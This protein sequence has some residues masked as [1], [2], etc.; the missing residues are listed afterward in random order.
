[1]EHANL[2]ELIAID[3][4]ASDNLTEELLGKFINN[5]GPQ[6]KGRIF[7][8]FHCGIAREMVFFLARRLPVRHEP[9]DRHPVEQ[10][11]ASP[12]G[13]QDPGDGVG[14]EDGHQDTH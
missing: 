11:A 2:K 9:R 1:M 6:L 7:F 3:L 8:Y 4:D 5:Y 13:R 14:G 10:P 12:Q